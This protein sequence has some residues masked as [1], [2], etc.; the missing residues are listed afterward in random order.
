MPKKKLTQRFIN[1]INKP[2]KTVS[3][4]DTKTKGLILRVTKK[5][6]KT[7]SYRYYEDGKNKRFTIGR[8]PKFS[9]KDARNEV[10]RI[11]TGRLDG[12]DPQL[13]RKQKRTAMKFNVLV[14][15]YKKKHLR[16]L[17]DSTKAEYERILDHELLPELGGYVADQ[18]NKK[19]IVRILDHKAYDENSATMANRIRAVLSSIFTFAEKQSI[20]DNNP[21]SKTDV[22]KSKPK[23]SNGFYETEDIK[24]L[25]NYFSDLDEPMGELLKILLLTGQRKTETASMKWTDIRRNVWTIPADLAKNGEPH[26]V[27]L[28]NIAKGI[29]DNLKSYSGDSQ[30]VF[31]SP[32]KDDKPLTS[33]KNVAQRIRKNTAVT[34][35]KVHNLRR[36][37]ITHMAKLGIARTI[38]GKV[39]N[40]KQASGDDLVTA[41][42]DKHSYIDEKKQAIQEWEKQLYIMLTG[43]SLSLMVMGEGRR[44]VIG[45]L[46]Y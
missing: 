4:Y 12:K 28:G 27:P 40:H 32:R 39:V 21:V 13:E 45:G 36:T 1:S 8:Y 14:K 18:I 15:E 35:F 34:D 29:I 37:V 11:K 31:L 22:Y 46:Y 17:R 42:Y 24:E 23:Q 6:T 20:V 9:L 38:V 44:K 25:W 2:E 30:Y 26:E 3:Y 5:G 19:H 7:F 16:T 43:D 41:I 33:T 10:Q